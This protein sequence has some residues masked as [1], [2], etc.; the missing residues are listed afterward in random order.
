MKIVDAAQEALKNLGRPAKVREIHDEIVKRELFTFGAKS[1]VSV[2]SGTMRQRT[3]GS[4]GLR[5]EA[6][7]RVKEPGVYELAK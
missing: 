3:E 7:F 4:P 6:I 1:P 2:L 5:G